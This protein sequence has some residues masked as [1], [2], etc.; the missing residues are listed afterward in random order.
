MN[1]FQYFL[2]QEDVRLSMPMK[3]FHFAV[4]GDYT[5]GKPIDP[6]MIPKHQVAYFEYSPQV[7]TVVLLSRET[8]PHSI[9]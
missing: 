4:E 5:G 6:K 9:S 2:F 1:S 3:I 7:E 8:D